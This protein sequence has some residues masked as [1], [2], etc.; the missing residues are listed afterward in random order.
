MHKPLVT[1]ILPS[2][3]VEKYI[4]ECI[5]SV[6]YQ[7][8]SELEI[9]CIDAGSTDGT[10]EIL[11]AYSKNDERIKVI[12]S[13]KKSYGR[14]VNMG[15]H[16]AKGKYVAVVETDDFIEM[17]M[18]EKLYEIAEENDLDFV[19]ADFKGFRTLGNGHRIY[20]K[21]RVWHNDE[22]YGKVVS[23]EDF[24][25]LYLR[26]VNIWKGIYR[27]DFLKKNRISLSETEG[28]AFQ[29]ISF[30]HLLLCCANRGMYIKDML[31]YYRRDNSDSSSNK[32]CG[33][34]FAYQE[35]SRLL[36]ERIITGNKELFYSYL[37]GR[38]MHIFVGEYE[39]A[40]QCNENFILEFR[41][42]I[43]WFKETLQEAVKNHRVT[44]GNVGEYIWE[45]ANILINN[46][47]VFCDEW[48]KHW[49]EKECAEKELLYRIGNSRIIIFGCG[50]YGRESLLFFDRHN[51]VIAAFCDNNH[52]LWETEYCGYS[53]QCPQKLL[54]QYLDAK[55]IISVKRH[56]EDIKK[57]LVTM[58]IDGSRIMSFR[59]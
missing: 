41:P 48:K 26:D 16:M 4:R 30:G 25:E 44:A 24:P 37:Y 51:I 50:N 23:V 14:Q 34:R 53:V 15:F 52:E 45:K 3:N 54:T 9:L 58:G 29:D 22:L 33:I 57:Q 13:N 47:K 46:E 6:A 56:Q 21:G 31:Y 5:D 19:K 40:M 20:D 49:R 55:I 38:M 35:Y 39:K 18:Y 32:P 28:A 8:L 10:L 43:E 27:R 17:H 59:E 42:I 11:E 12:Q 7:S 1:V 2:L 36:K